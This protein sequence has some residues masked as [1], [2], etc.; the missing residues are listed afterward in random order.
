MRATF[1]VHMIV[2]DVDDDDRLT[3]I[4]TV[5]VVVEQQPQQPTTRTL[6]SRVR[7]TLKGMDKPTLCVRACTYKH[8]REGH[9]ELS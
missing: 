9:L 6:G 1:P 7:I 4:I 5:V 2:L 3:Q 8:T